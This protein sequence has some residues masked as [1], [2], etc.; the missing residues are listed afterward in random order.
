MSGLWGFPG[1][2]RGLLPLLGAWRGH[3]SP[4]C[5]SAWAA[6]QG[7]GRSKRFVAWTGGTERA[8]VVDGYVWTRVPGTEVEVRV[9]GDRPLALR[10]RHRASGANSRL[11]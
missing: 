3:S 5:N 10:Y 7:A 4:Q 2:L 8:M 9:L 1:C 11:P 6:V